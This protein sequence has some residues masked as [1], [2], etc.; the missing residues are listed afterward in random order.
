MANINKRNILGND[1]Q[2]PSAV[3][4]LVYN[5]AA[6]ANKVAEVGK[7]L[8]PLPKPGVGTGYT[9]DVSGGAYPLPNAGRNLAVYNN[10]GTVAAITFGTDGTVTALAAGVTDSSGRVG[11]PCMPNSWSYFAGGFSN[12]VIS[13]SSSLMVFLINDSTSIQPVA[14]TFNNTNGNPV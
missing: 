9:T 2:D 13:S 3:D 12:W 10:S 1:V 14:Q 6:G 5:N 8:L 11:L 7:H 4:V